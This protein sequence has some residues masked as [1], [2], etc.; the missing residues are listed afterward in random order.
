MIQGIWGRGRLRTAMP[1]ILPTGW[2]DGRTVRPAA[3]WMTINER[4]RIQPP[5]GGMHGVGGAKGLYLLSTISF[6]TTHVVPSWLV[7]DIGVI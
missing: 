1:V 6:Y 7:V 2:W 3:L 5:P 4:S